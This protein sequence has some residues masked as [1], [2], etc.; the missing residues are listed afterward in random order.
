M[1]Q[2]RPRACLSN[3][4][5]A[6]LCDVPPHQPVTVCASSRRCLAIVAVAVHFT[7]FFTEFI[8][9]LPFRSLDPHPLL[10]LVVIS[11]RS[12]SQSNLPH[13]CPNSFHLH[14]HPLQSFLSTTHP[15]QPST[16][17]DP[18]AQNALIAQF[19]AIAGTSTRQVWLT[20]IVS[21]CSRH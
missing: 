14:L 1:A 12:P 15:S 21:A 19:T 8:T 11:F 7:H 13:F 2:W 3:S 10:Y 16:M 9:L 18:A 20:P 6:T 4:S 5:Q 17:A